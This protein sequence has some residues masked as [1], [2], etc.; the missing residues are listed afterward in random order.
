V[1]LLAALGA[2]HL[3]PSAGIYVSRFAELFDAQAADGHSTGVMHVPFVDKFFFTHNLSLLFTIKGFH[4]A[5]SQPRHFDQM[6]PAL[7]GRSMDRA[8]IVILN[9]LIPNFIAMG[10]IV[11]VV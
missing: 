2:G 11:R 1:P 5:D 4:G 6:L 9:A 7:T 8:T 3:V 10:I